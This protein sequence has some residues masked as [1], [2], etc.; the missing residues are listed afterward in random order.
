MRIAPCV[1]LAWLLVVSSVVVADELADLKKQLKEAEAKVA[2]LKE[3]V[4]AKEGGEPAEYK[5][6]G[7]IAP[8][9]MKVGEKGKLINPR[10]MRRLPI[11]IHKVVSIIDEYTLVLQPD[12]EDNRMPYVIV[13]G[14]LTKGMADGQLLNADDRVWKVVGTEKR[15]QE[16]LMVIRPDAK[17]FPPKRR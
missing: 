3:K 17:A 14:L 13:K 1:G 4:A 15:N 5:D 12:F 6:T 2:E 16:T 10:D 7:T 9:L 11:G 8:G